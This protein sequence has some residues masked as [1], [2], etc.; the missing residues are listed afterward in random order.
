LFELASNIDL[1][2]MIPKF[3]PKV[4]P[5]VG[6]RLIFSCAPQTGSWLALLLRQSQSPHA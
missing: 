6:S 1:Q 3:K 5:P 4:M 2:E